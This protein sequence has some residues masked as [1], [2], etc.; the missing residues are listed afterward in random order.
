MRVD[1][2][3]GI[4][5]VTMGLTCVAAG[6]RDGDVLRGQVQSIDDE[7][8]TFTL[9]DDAGKEWT[10]QWDDRTAFLTRPRVGLKMK[11]TIEG[12][13]GPTRTVLATRVGKAEKTPD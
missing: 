12:K 9:M 1:C 11:V 7:A 3:I 8:K 2:V 5:I 6:A 4:L 10:V 13:A